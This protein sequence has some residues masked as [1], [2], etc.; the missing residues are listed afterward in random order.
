MSL[1]PYAS[2]GGRHRRYG[3]PAPLQ[4]SLGAVAVLVLLATTARCEPLDITLFPSAEAEGDQAPDA[5]APNDPSPPP[6]AGAPQLCM[7]DAPA[8]DE[9]V[10]RDDCDGDLRCHPATGECVAEC[11]AAETCAGANVCNT[12]FAVCVECIDDATCMDEDLDLCDT[13]GGR[14]VECVIDADCTDDV[15][16]RPVCLRALGV[17]GCNTN[18]DCEEGSCE[19]GECDDDS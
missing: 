8:C 11:S 7:P 19:Q 9:C 10:A 15:E 5:S 1:Q 16:E 4:R 18:D 17:C 13:R 2:D 3:T 12:D 6:D 14:C